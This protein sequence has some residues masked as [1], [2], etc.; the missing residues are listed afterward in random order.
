[1]LQVDINQQASLPDAI[2]ESQLC[3]WIKSAY[4]EQQSPVAAEVSVAIVEP[5]TIQA[6][7]AEFREQEKPTNVLAF[8]AGDTAQGETRHLGDI[9]LCAA[10]IEREAM[11]QR[12][13]SAFHWAHMAVHGMLHLQ[14]YDHIEAGQAA[15]MENLEIK[16]L[17]GLGIANPYSHE[18]AN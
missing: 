12:K 4:L 1:M 3:A 15:R 2:D 14:G 8:P 18:L 17:A 7:N 6:L 16:L 13:H 9:V 11:D 10:I 5:H